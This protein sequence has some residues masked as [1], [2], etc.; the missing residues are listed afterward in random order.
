[1]RGTIACWCQ[2]DGD[3]HNTLKD[4]IAWPFHYSTPITNYD[5]IASLAPLITPDSLYVLFIFLFYLCFNASIDWRH[6]GATRHWTLNIN[7][8]ENGYHS[9]ELV[10]GKA[11]MRLVTTTNTEQL[12]LTYS[13][14]H[15]L[16]ITSDQ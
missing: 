15:I 9:S 2:G 5:S 12:Y 6:V 11:P 13:M 8:R 16:V 1:M 10:M 3:T 4:R 14:T 7:R